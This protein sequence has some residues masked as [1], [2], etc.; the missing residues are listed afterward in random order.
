[1][2]RVFSYQKL[3]CSCEFWLGERQPASDSGGNYFYCDNYRDARN[4]AYCS[5]N[6]RDMAANSVPCAQYQKWCCL[7]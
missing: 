3:C 4:K 5:V 7:R 6:K 1:M 2:D